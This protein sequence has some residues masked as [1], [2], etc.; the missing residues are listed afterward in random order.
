MLHQGKLKYSPDSPLRS[1]SAG[2]EGE[3]PLGTFW[4]L[5]LQLKLICRVIKQNPEKN[6][7]ELTE[8]MAW[9]KRLFFFF[10]RVLM[11]ECML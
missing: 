3:A 2:M 9:E 1:L 4:Y 5:N 7:K 6:N 10:L 11:T 8:E